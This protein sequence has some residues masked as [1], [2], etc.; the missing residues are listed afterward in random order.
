MRNLQNDFQIHS[1]RQARNTHIG[2]LVARLVVGAAV[3]T[4]VAIATNHLYQLSPNAMTDMPLT[5]T[6]GV[7]ACLIIDSL[8]NIAASNSSIR[9]ARAQAPSR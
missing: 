9:A 7:F 4:P 1:L 3:T 5:G 2:A 6:L 8:R